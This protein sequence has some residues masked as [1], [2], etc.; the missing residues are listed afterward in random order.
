MLETQP[1]MDPQR[2]EIE[3]VETLLPAPKTRKLRFRGWFVVLLATAAWVL[4]IA[5]AVF[6]FRFS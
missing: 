5:F 3:E 4:V 2:F 6:L 1:A